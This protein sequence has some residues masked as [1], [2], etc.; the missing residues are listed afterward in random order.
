M[1]NPMQSGQSGQSGQKISVEDVVSKLKDDGDFDRLRLKIIR[2][3]KDNEG[4]RSNIVSVVKQSAA[5]NRAGA[6]NTKL[7][8]LCDAI[9]EEI[10]ENVMNQ[11]SDGLWEI[12]RSSDGMNAEIRETVQSVYNKLANPQGN[13]V[14]ESASSSGQVPIQR[15]N[16]HNGSIKIS[17]GSEGTLPDAEFREP[18]GFSKCNHMQSNHNETKLQQPV[19]SDSRPLE[20]GGEPDQC[21][22]PFDTEG[23]DHSLPPGFS[24]LGKRKQPSDGSDEDPDLPP[25]FG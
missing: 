21:H 13:E 23:A 20:D 10:R 19:P 24:S 5:L 2:K 6:E 4:L 17:S 18:L 1:A 9:H 25:G 22:E 16:G 12:I 11:I 14:G 7:S 15:G 8:Q 3:F